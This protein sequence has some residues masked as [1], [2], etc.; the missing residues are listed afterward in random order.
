MQLACTSKLLL[1]VFVCL[2]TCLS[3]FVFHF[4]RTEQ[5]YRFFQQW[6]P[7][8]HNAT[9]E[10]SDDDITS[11]G[12]CAPDE[13]VNIVDST[14]WLYVAVKHR[15]ITPLFSIQFNSIQFFIFCRLCKYIF[16]ICAFLPTGFAFGGDIL[17]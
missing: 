17:F 12:Y 11:P 14:P 2:F 6:C 1:F 13:E 8:I 9:D 10:E 15:K 4:I 5:V 16:L 7:N 3:V